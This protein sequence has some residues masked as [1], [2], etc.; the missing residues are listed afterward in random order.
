MTSKKLLGAFCLAT[1]AVGITWVVLAQNGRYREIGCGRLPYDIPFDP[2]LHPTAQEYRQRFAKHS[3]SLARR[4][5]GNDRNVDLD[6]LY[7]VPFFDEKGGTLFID[8]RG[9]VVLAVEYPLVFDFSEGLAGVGT[10]VDAKGYLRDYG[11]ID[12][13]GKLVIAAEYESVTPFEEGLAVVQKGDKHGFINTAGEVVIPLQ[14]QRASSFRDGVAEVWV[15]HNNKRLIDRTGRVLYEGNQWDL[16]RFSEGLVYAN[17]PGKA[18][19][20]ERRRGYLDSK[21][22]FA[23]Y[24]DMKDSGSW[25]TRCEEFHEGRAAIEF[26]TLRWGF[27]DRAGKLVV[28]PDYAQVDNYS[29]GL[30]AV[31]IRGEPSFR[32][33][34]IDLQGS[35][36]IQA[37]FLNAGPFKEGLAPVLVLLNQNAAPAAVGEAAAT[38]QAKWAYIDRTGRMV[39][40]PR[41]YTAAPFKNGLALVSENPYHSGYIDKTSAYVFEVTRPK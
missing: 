13:T 24:F 22:E 7:S 31:G 16:G 12:R 11:F 14:Y 30:A 26:G 38:P 40:P 27:I 1:V 15:D 20:G 25:A 2:P 6:K 4:A 34:Y 37:Q 21:F 33:G 29:E 23:F 8:N 18:P 10:R 9:E 32:Y 39:I 36:I 41:F 19:T 3:E 17:L 28:P 35:R 5:K